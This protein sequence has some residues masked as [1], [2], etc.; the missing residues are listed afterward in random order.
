MGV[1]G[2]TEHCI[3]DAEAAKKAEAARK[4]A[5]ADREKL[6]RELSEAIKRNE[7]AT[8]SLEAALE[9]ARVERDRTEQASR[10]SLR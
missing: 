8:R 10:R 1:P 5:E 3:R 4:N 2:L 7:M 6:G 9:A